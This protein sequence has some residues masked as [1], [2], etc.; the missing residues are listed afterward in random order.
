M[1]IRSYLALATVLVAMAGPVVAETLQDRV[2]RQLDEDGYTRVEVS[3]TFLGRVRMVA[4][5]PD[6]RREIV[7]SPSTG[8]ILRDYEV[9]G[10]GASPRIA[11][12]RTASRSSTSGGNESTRQFGIAVAPTSTVTATPTVGTATFADGEAPSGAGVGSG[13]SGQPGTT[14]E[15][16]DVGTPSTGPDDGAQGTS[17]EE[18]TDPG[19]SDGQASEP[20]DNASEPEDNGSEATDDG[21]DDQSD[22]Q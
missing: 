20:E 1:V 22:V 15:P 8:T 10:E 7:I 4:T 14:A 19:D 3:R 21:S 5:A 13:A 6:A 12:T 18:A 16:E 17:G 2:I 9:R 11:R